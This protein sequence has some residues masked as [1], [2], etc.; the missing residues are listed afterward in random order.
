VAPTRA[1]L[2]RFDELSMRLGEEMSPEEM[3][4]VLDEQ[5]KLQDAIEAAGAWELLLTAVTTAW[6]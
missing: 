6:R 5:A 4:R 1:R 3:E 2:T